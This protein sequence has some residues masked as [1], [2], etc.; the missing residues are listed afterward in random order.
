MGE[1]DAEV[2]IRIATGI[3]ALIRVVGRP[4]G[5]RGNQTERLKLAMKFG[6]RRR[7]RCVY[8]V[9]DNRRWGG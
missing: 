6:R 1:G 5:R 9:V 7:A 8:A 3:M 2:E 4:M